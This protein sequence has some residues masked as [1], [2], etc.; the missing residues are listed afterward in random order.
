VVTPDGPDEF[1]AVLRARANLGATG[2]RQLKGPF[3]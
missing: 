3:I 2:P 1:E